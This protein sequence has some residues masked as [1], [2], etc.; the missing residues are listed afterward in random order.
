MQQTTWAHR[1]RRLALAF[2]LSVLATLIPV[3]DP[4]A[5][6]L[7]C[8]GVVGLSG[9][10]GGKAT[11]AAGPAYVRVR[12]G[13]HD[14]HYPYVTWSGYGPYVWAQNGSPWSHKACPSG[15]VLDWVD[16]AL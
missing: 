12:I 16:Y 3:A 8:Q 6:A 10:N 1:L 15:F 14:Y 11:C 9:S 2:A 7:A 13:C 4:P 5:Q